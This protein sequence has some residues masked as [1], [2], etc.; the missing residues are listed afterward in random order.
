TGMLLRPRQKL[1]HR[2]RNVGD[3]AAVVNEHDLRAPPRRREAV[4]GNREVDDVRS[5]MRRVDVA[6]IRKLRAEGAIQQ[7]LL[8]ER[9]EVRAIEPQEIDRSIYIAAGRF[10]VPVPRLRVGATAHLDV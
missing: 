10:F 8:P 7:T 1:R 5:N 4:D 3:A 9:E 2:M 6:I